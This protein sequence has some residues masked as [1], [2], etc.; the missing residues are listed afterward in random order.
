MSDIYTGPTYNLDMTNKAAVQVKKGNADTFKKYGLFSLIFAVIYTFCLYKNHDAITYPIYMLVT[1]TLLHFLRKKDGLSL[2]KSKSGSST[3]GLFYVVSLM[4]LSIHKCMSTNGVL[5]WLD[6]LAIFLLF[7]SFMLYLYMDTTG[8][9]II[10][11]ISGIALAVF[12]PISRLFAPF[13]DMS[14]WIKSKKVKAPSEKKKNIGAVGIGILCAIPVLLIVLLLLSSADVVFNSL[15]EKIF[16]IFVLPEN[17]LDF[18]GIGFKLVFGF[19]LAYLVPYVLDKG[20]VKVATKQEGHVN[21]VIAITFTAIIGSV[22][23]VFSL[24]Q[25]L[26]LFTGSMGLPKGIS[27]AQYAHEGFYQ[28]LA[29]CILNVAMVSICTRLFKRSKALSAILLIIGGCTYI[30]IASSAMR[31]VMYIR[32]YQLTF[33][34][35]FVLWFLAVLCLWLAFL[36]VSVINRNFPIFKACMVAVTV[37]YIGFVFANPDYQIAKYDLQAVADGKVD[38]YKDVDNYIVE[39]LSTDAAPALIGNEK[40]LHQF[41]LNM[42][43]K[44]GYIS[45]RYDTV[46]GFNFS[47]NRAKKLF[48]KFK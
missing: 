34:R 13:N 25:V 5:L 16:D 39:N 20:D 19:L 24:I 40:L 17:F 37:A 18:I 9:D 11:W 21:P 44:W 3:L 27:Y 43:N 7:F 45:K 2:I 12:T 47:Y 15:I 38:D 42:E 29:V 10:E 35:L 26:Y 31:M 4:L 23:V 41:Q 33:L 8:W 14:E 6:S 28:L 36:L 32:V 48:G 46:R 1:L 30:M 22:Y